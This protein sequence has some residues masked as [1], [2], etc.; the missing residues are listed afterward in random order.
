M[1]SMMRTGRAAIDAG[2]RLILLIAPVGGA[3]AQSDSSHHEETPRLSIHGFADIQAE[4]RW[5][6]GS[7]TSDFHLGQF[8]LFL[9]SHL[10]PSIGFLAETVFEDGGVDVE[11][12]L[13]RYTRS[14]RLRLAAGRGHAALGYWNDAYHHGALLQPTI[15]RPQGLRFEDDGGILPVHFVGVELSGTVPVAGW[16]LRYAANVSNG[17]GATRDEVQE[18]RDL[19]RNKATA[20]KLSIARTGPWELLVGGSFYRDLIPVTSGPVRERIAGAHFSVQRD[21]LQIISEVYHLTHRPA[22]GGA[23]QSHWTGYGFASLGFGRWH[24]YAAYDR[25]DVDRNDPYFADG[26]IDLTRW[27]AGLRFDVTAS[28]AFKAELRRERRPGGN[29]TV[30]AV[31]TAFAF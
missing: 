14:D 24:P 15:E 9:V 20:L 22:A 26:E 16:E 1:T 23:D 29:T 12:L 21:Q 28:N 10:S 7:T 5:S 18:T 2:I 4:H 31:Q 11:R 17:R 8:D 3:W 6:G 27:I 13:I 25:L 19:N 30:I